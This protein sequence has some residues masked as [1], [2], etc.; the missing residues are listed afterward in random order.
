ME[1]GIVS[2]ESAGAPCCEVVGIGFSGAVADTDA[3]LFLLVDFFVAGRFLVVFFFL[4]DGVC[5][6]FVALLSATVT[7]SNEI[8]VLD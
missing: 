1:P 8:F 4:E 5:C 7:L 2:W 6:P 3:V